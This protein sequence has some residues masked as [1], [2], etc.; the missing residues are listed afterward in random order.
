MLSLNQWSDSILKQKRVEKVS[1]GKK[2]KKKT[3]TKRDM[4]MRAF[5][6]KVGT[7]FLSIHLG[8]KVC[9]G[10]GGGEEDYW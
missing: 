6:K 9:G 2:K 3:K 1:W 4:Y 8:N 7:I 5:T 10:G